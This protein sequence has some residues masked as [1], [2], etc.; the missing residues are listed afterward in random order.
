M[1][2]TVHKL[3]HSRAMYR[4]AAMVAVERALPSFG[5]LPFLHQALM[6]T[7]YPG[8]E[9]IVADGDRVSATNWVRQPFSASKI[10][11]FKSTVLVNRVNLFW[12]LHWQ[13]STEYVT[14]TKGKMDILISCVDTRSARFEIICSPL[15]KEC[16]Y[17]LDIGNTSD[18]GQFVLRQPKNGRNRRTPDRLATV[19]EFVTG[20][21]QTRARQG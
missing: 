9:V 7:G 1:P 20:D 18:G 14:R 19:A 12:D 10:G 8:L 13:P 11:L 2:P 21:R 6:A 3:A 17:W 4:V 5:G 15:F 16:V